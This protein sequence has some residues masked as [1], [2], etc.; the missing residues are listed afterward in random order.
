MKRAQRANSNKTWFQKKSQKKIL[1]KVGR[2]RHQ[3]L[4]L[5]QFYG[6][7]AD[8][9]VNF[10]FVLFYPGEGGGGTLLCDLNGDVRPDRLWFSECFVLNGVSISSLF[11]LNRVVL[12]EL[13]A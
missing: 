13:M 5:L 9:T 6:H 2:P 1:G 7:R 3:F 8:L 4:P 12:H 11:V 10:Q